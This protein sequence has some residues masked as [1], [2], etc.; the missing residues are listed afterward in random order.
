[1]INYAIVL[2]LVAEGIVTPMV[3]MVVCQERYTT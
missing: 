1:M 3:L 2:N